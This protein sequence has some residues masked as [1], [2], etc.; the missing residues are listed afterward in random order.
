M[1][2]IALLAAILLVPAVAA[3]A[4]PPPSCPFTAGALPADTLP[5]GTPHGDQIPVDHIVVLMQENRSFDHYFRRALAL[6]PNEA[7][8][9][10]TASN[11][12][13]LGGN[14]IKPFYKTEY[15]EVA[16]LDH[17][18]NAS[19]LQWNDG[20]MD[21]F[22]ATNVEAEDPDGS[23]TMGFYKRR[24]LPYYYK[25]YR[26]FATGDRYFCSLLG[27][28]W[29]N[30]FYLMAGTS[31]GHIHNDFPSGNDYM[32]PSIFDRLDDAG[33]S[34]KVYQSQVTI[35][36]VFYH[37]RQRLDHVVPI[38]EYFADAA[39]GTLPQ[40]SFVDPVFFSSDPNVQSD[41]HPPA[42]V[43]IGEAFTASVLNALMASPNWASSAAFLTYDEHG[44][45]FDHVPPP[46]ACVPDPI[47]P[48]GNASDLPAAFDRYG[49]RVPFVAV[50]PWAKRR[51]RSHRVYDHTSV[52]RFIET[53]FDLPALTARDANADPLLELF[54]FSA[55]TFK[56]PPKLPPAPIGPVQAA[57]CTVI[58]GGSAELDD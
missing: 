12:D 51:F 18:W 47:P 50:S 53:R 33:I 15:C 32:Q 19:H 46:P 57:A 3:S 35:A 20:A 36:L 22:T 7:A 38:A 24:D 8:A 5:A 30:R 2:A 40:V 21:G 10:R 13:P 58:V 17:S 11:P 42:N 23:R 55:P 1:R 45:F 9:L 37:V 54:D 26:S 49:I 56:K 31:F 16:D 6:Q 4:D 29:P 44:G 34:W 27:P 41:E 25:L 43:Q 28:T 14:P 48:T 52:L 39:A